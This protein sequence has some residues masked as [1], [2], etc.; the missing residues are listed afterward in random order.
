MPRLWA[1]KARLEVPERLRRGKRKEEAAWRRSAH[2][3]LS[4]LTQRLGLDDLQGVSLLDVGC[5]TRFAAAIVN[6]GVPI[7]RYVGVDAD[8]EII[9]HLRANVDDPRFQFWHLNAH[10]ELYNP[11]GAPLADLQLVPTDER[12][13]V[14]SLFSVFTHLAPHDFRPM[15]EAVRPHVVGDGRLVFSLFVNDEAGQEPYQLEVQ[16]RI[17]GEILVAV[18]T[19]AETPD[20]VDRIPDRPLMEAVYSEQY[21]RRLIDGSG[22]EVLSLHLPERPTIQHHF[23]CRPA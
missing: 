13:D 21:A 14:I 2:D 9:D 6:D 15:L 18:A 16:R 22:W 1:V 4:V 11:D 19:P 12:F 7:G 5:G 3:L 17:D 10:N 23:V 20:F 8:K